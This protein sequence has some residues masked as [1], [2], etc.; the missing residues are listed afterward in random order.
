MGAPGGTLR[1][2]KLQGIVKGLFPNHSANPIHCLADL[3]C[4]PEILVV[5][6][7]HDLIGFDGLFDD[8]GFELQG[9]QDGCAFGA[10]EA[11]ISLV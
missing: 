7:N 10:Q 5:R 11:E 1:D 8:F 4:W 9:D 3:G 2:E 6:R